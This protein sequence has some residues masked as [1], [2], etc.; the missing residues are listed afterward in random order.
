[1]R[2]KRL[3]VLASFLYWYIVCANKT[4]SQAVDSGEAGSYS[5][6]DKITDAGDVAVFV[7]RGVEIGR[8][9]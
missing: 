2:T 6:L 3:S 8:G 7:F 9:R 1:M 4:F 5:V